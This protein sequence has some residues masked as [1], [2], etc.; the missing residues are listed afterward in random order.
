MNFDIAE[1][2]IQYSNTMLIFYYSLNK[3]IIL[4]SNKDFNSLYLI[5]YFT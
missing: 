2:I 1:I 5:D 4:F 3:F